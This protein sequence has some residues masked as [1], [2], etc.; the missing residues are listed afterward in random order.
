[1]KFT[2]YEL[3]VTGCELRVAGYELRVVSYELR[4]SMPHLGSWR[5]RC[6]ISYEKGQKAQKG[7]KNGQKSAFFGAAFMQPNS[8]ELSLSSFSGSLGTPLRRRGGLLLKESIGG[9]SDDVRHRLTLKV[10]IAPHRLHND[11]S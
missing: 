4:V 10:S 8:R 5:K 3:R 6:L 7:Q 1:L 11:E 2:G 9:V